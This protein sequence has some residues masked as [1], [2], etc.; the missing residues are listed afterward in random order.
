MQEMQ[1]QVFLLT[2]GQVSNQFQ[3]I[4]LCK[5]KRSR[6]FSIG[7]GSGV[8]TALVT[9]VARA[10]NGSAE[11]VQDNEKLEPVC[12]AML[13]KASSLAISDICISW[14][15]TGAFR[16]QTKPPPIFAGSGFSGFSL[17]PSG[18]VPENTV[19]KL[20]GTAPAGPLEFV[21]PIP[22]KAKVVNNSNEAILHKMF[23]RSVIRDVEE[24]ERALQCS[25]QSLKTEAI[26]FSIQHSVLCSFTAFVAVE[27]GGTPM[28]HDVQV[29]R[30]EFSHDALAD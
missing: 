27:Q 29:L 12:I 20:T 9:G 15:S 7:I 14:P 21:V 2:D 13:K 4:D 23:A 8:S 28:E 22:A 5:S 30:R 26:Q 11:F 3:V 25:E 10:T 19:V 1:R 24:I 17:Y 6:V 18:A 16:S